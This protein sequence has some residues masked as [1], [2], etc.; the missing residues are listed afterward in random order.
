TGRVQYPLGRTK[1]QVF[2][3]EWA[4]DG[5]RL[6]V[7]YSPHDSIHPFRP[8]CGVVTAGSGDVACLASDYFIAPFH[9]LC[10]HPDNRTILSCGARGITTQVVR[11]ATAT[12]SVRP[13]TNAAGIHEH[14]RCGA[15]GTRLV[16]TY[17]TL[18]TV[19]EVYLLSADG[20]E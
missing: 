9:S 8:A 20:R 16:C 12:G 1:R 3:P 5:L 4:P 19:P 11:V 7:P 17:R 13:V 6:A 10:W 2:T 18:T 15:D 14:L